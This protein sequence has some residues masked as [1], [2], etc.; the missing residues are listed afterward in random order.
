MRK[1][2]RLVFA[3]T[4]LVS[5]NNAT[6]QNYCEPPAFGFQFCSTTWSIDDITIGSY[7]EQNSGCNSFSYWSYNATA[8]ISLTKGSPV[9]FSLASGGDLVQWSIWVDCNSDG[10]FTDATDYHWA[11]TSPSSSVSGNIIIPASA[12]GTSSRMRIMSS[13]QSLAIPKANACIFPYNNET[14]DFSVIL[15]S[16][17]ACSVP[18]NLTAVPGVT[19]AFLSWDSVGTQYNLEYGVAGFTQGAGTTLNPTTNTITL[20]GLTAN[21]QY[22][23][24][25]QNDCSAASGDSSSWNGPISFTT[26]CT[27]ISAFPALETFDSTSIW[28]PNVSWPSNDDTISNC[29]DRSPSGGFNYRWIL[30][31]GATTSSNTGPDSDY[32]GTGSYMHVTDYGTT[33]TEATFTSPIYNTNSLTTPFLSFYYH[34]Y[35]LQMGNLYVDVSTNNGSTWITLDSIVGQQQTSKSAAWLPRLVDVS[36]YKSASFLYRFRAKSTQNTSNSQMAIDNI[37]LAEAPPCPIPGSFQISNITGTS[38]DLSW[39]GNATQYY[40]EIGLAGFSQGTG[41]IDTAT[42]SS[43]SITNLTGDTWYDVYIQSGC[44][45]NG[46]SS[47]VG[48]YQFKTYITPTWLQDF[49]ADGFLPN[50]DWGKAGGILAQPTVFTSTF[51]S[52]YEDGWLNNGFDGAVRVNISNFS[53]SQ[54]WFFTEK[55]DLGTGNNWEIHF[56]AALTLANST[57]A[58]SLEADDTLKVVISTDGGNTWNKSNTLLSISQANNLGNSSQTFVADLSGYSGVIKVGFYMESSIANTNALDFF[59]DNLGIRVPVS[60][61][62]P[63]ALNATN[64][65]ANA[66]TLGWTSNISPKDFVL[67]Y[68]PKGFTQGTGTIVTGITAD[69][70]VVTGLQ[71]VTEYDF[72]ISSICGNDTSAGS[73]TTLLTGCP[74]VFSTPYFADFDVLSAGNPPPGGAWNNCWVSNNSTGFFYRWQTGDG[75]SQWA[76]TGP[77]ADHT[78]GIAGEG[79]YMYTEAS[80]S[81]IDATL[82]NGP[83]DLSQLAEPTLTFWYHMFGAQMGDLHVDISTDMTTWLEDVY[84]L[85]GQQQNS[86]SANWLQAKIALSQYATDSIYVR[87]RAVKG[88]GGEGD[89]AIDDVAIEEANGCIAASGLNAVNKTTTSAELVW[90]S[91]AVN[92]SIEWGPVGFTQGSGQST[93]VTGIAGSSYLLTGLT[94]GTGYDFYVQDTCNPNIWV[95]PKTFFTTCVSAYNGTYTVGGTTSAFPNLEAAIE[96]LSNCGISG[97]VVL[98]LQGIKDTLTYTLEANQIPGHNAN[99]TLTIQGNGHDSIYAYPTANY[100]FAFNGSSYVTIKNVSL[101]NKLGNFIFWMY[102]GANNISIEDCQLFA[103]DGQAI[104]YSSAAIAATALPT[105]ATSYGQNAYHVT[106]SGNSIYNGY[107]GISFNGES[108][109]HVSGLTVENNTFILPYNYGLR[110]NYTDTLAI[111]GNSIQGV[112]STSFGYGIYLSNGEQFVIQRTI[113]PLQVPPSRCLV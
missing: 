9:S 71:P 113:L 39:T 93:I 99:N 45:G 86:G 96:S 18:V 43:F 44:S 16:P 55:I 6:A 68:G 25:V 73:M 97:P 111:N 98:N 60:C 33:G 103:Y 108:V 12:T 8:N 26:A 19:D 61:P 34:M 62:A 84:T 51:S 20:T 100:L 35:G 92:S 41:V 82:I 106:V 37:L 67:E 32:S 85:S 49:D 53:T 4:L 15:G 23:F 63:T 5:F 70:V 110:V 66:L 40:I 54:D 48:P 7:S 28:I 107:A 69:S 75:A 3:L 31:E 59:V 38:V 52:W 74:A 30:R 87:F 112:G 65:T 90:G 56:D 10:D 79:T 80:N 13:A 14:Q 101:F 104:N 109:N 64:V 88:T 47:W 58:G 46:F 76:N 89:M 2:V 78:T 11:S 72:Y 91:Y 94:A 57:L 50:T 22:D 81:G 29:W 95:G 77:D 102:N 36:G 21:T 24:Y 42:G 17:G 105:S 1:L 27:E 83:F